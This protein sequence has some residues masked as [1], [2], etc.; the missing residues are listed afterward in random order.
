MQGYSTPD[1]CATVQNRTA[2]PE[3]SVDPA[4]SQLTSASSTVTRSAATPGRAGEEGAPC[5]PP[6]ITIAE[7]EGGQP[8]QI[9]LQIAGQA[10]TL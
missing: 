9:R 3:N 5:S 8:I 1:Q 4:R 2:E 7:R 6:C 10:T